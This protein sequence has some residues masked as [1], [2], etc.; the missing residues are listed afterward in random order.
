MMKRLIILCEGTTEKEFCDKLLYT[1]F[2]DLN[3][4]IQAAYPRWSGGGQIAWQPLLKQLLVTL[5]QDRSAYVT[6]F[7]DLYGLHAPENFP[8]W[9][10]ALSLRQ[11]PY[12]RVAMLES[13]MLAQIPSE[14]QHRFIP[15]LI[16]HEFEGLLFNEVVHFERQFED[17]EF[18][19]KT[20]LER[21]LRQFPNPEL[22][23]DGKKTSPSYRLEETI[24]HRFRKTIHGIGLAEDIGLKQ[25]RLKSKHFNDWIS[26]LEVI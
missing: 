11:T 20:E 5:K 12:E 15:N 14:F 1:H 19:N 7:I 24:F 22:I 2:F 21:V 18:K 8:K 13:G 10:E 17:H 23:N 6:T 25:M 4:V 26:K 3:I 9:N 16:L